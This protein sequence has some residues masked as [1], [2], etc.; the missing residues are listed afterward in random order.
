MAVLARPDPALRTPENLARIFE[1]FGR[2]E[3]PQLDAKLYQN[4]SFA[5]AKDADLLAIAAR[6]SATQPTPNLLFGAVHYLLLGG[7]DHALRAWYPALAGASCREPE[8]AF[9]AFRDFCLQHREAIEALVAT[10]LTQTNVV[11]RCSGLLPGFARVFTREG[12]RPLALVEIGASA[13]LNLGWDRY[14]YAYRRGSETA[15]GW[16]DS[17]SRV[18]VECE[19]RG[20]VALPALPEAIP[21]AWRRGVDIQPIDL[22]EDDAVQWL[23]GLVWPEHVGR[24]E[25]LTNAIELARRAPPFLVAADAAAALPALLEAAP[26]DAVACVYGTHTLYQFSRDSLLSTFKA[27]QAASFARAVYFLSCEGT[28]DRCSELKLTA[29]RGGVRETALLARCNPHGRWL[30]WLV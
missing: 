3:C 21:V 2:M 26:A 20:D 12:G 14:R 7:E 27:M 10:R 17:A 6:A 15:L 24:Q 16:G 18:L 1:W 19:L 13:G 23:R 28:G 11:Q 8:T 4:L 25:R 22:G 30:E 9:P 29:Y 5:I